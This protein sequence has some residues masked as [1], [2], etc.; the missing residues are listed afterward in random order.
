MLL[1]FGDIWTTVPLCATLPGVK[2]QTRFIHYPSQHDAFH[3][4]DD[5]LADS[6]GAGL[7]FGPEVAGKSDLI[8]QIAS[9]VSERAAVAVIDGARIKPTQFLATTLTEFGYELELGSVEEL[10]SM[11]SVFAVQQTRSRE[12]PVLIIENFNRMYPS[13]LGVLC[14]LAAL[15]AGDHYAIRIILVG[16]N[17][18]EQVTDAP[19][20]N[21]VTDRLCG[22]LGLQPLTARE[23][24]VYLFAR[25]QSLGIEH[26][27]TVFVADVCKALHEATQ[28]WPGN[29]DDVAEAAAARADQFPIEL[30]VALADCCKGT[31][32][33]ARAPE[34]IVSYGGVV[35]ARIR[36]VRDRYLV[37]R[38]DLSDIVVDNRYVSKLHALL[39]KSE[40]GLVLVDMKSRNGTYV[41]SKRVRNRILRNN[42]VV[43][44]GDYR[45]KVICP[46]TY[47][48]TVKPDGELAD[49]WK[50][51]TFE[52]ARR[53]RLQPDTESPQQR[54]RG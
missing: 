53:A 38:S 8:E 48:A 18:Y 17:D 52:D 10:A 51:Q 29:L 7:L 3:F 45:I 49:T 26:P 47:A 20:M 44:I 9:K 2:R 22:R 11:L 28:G 14:R 19:G 46:A 50:M 5:V 41:N 15:R 23:S 21:T 16:D 24:L 36:L 42:D 35:T 13:S 37:G 6:R 30:D 27:D 31:D 54:S 34:L 33:D 40:H 43:S 1:P 25:L 39:V 4:L 12:A 32:D